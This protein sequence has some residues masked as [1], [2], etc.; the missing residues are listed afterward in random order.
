MTFITED[1]L[2]SN[3]VAVELYHGT[4]KEL[5]IVDY[6]C[7]L[8]PKD[9]AINRQFANLYEIWLE[10]D[11]YKWRAMRTAG[12]PEEK[13]TGGATPLE[14]FMAYAE[15]VPLTLRNPL[16]HWSHLELQRYFG[17][18][19][20]LS[21]NTAA[22]IWEQANSM[23]QGDDFTT[24]GL[25]KKFRV[26]VVCTT[27]DPVDDLRWHRE[28]FGKETYTRTFPAF[29]PDKALAVDQP[30]V[31]VEWLGKLEAAADIYIVQ[32]ADFLK[33]L[34]QRLSFFHDCGCRL[35]DH[36]L[37]HAFA[38]ACSTEEAAE[39]FAQARRGVEANAEQKRKFAAYLLE[40]F[41]E[42]YHERGWVS[43]FHLGAQ[44][45]NSQR[46]LRELG[47]DT[48]F[49][50]IGDWPQASALAR[51][52]DALDRKGKLGKTIL[53]NLNPADNYVFGTMIGNFQEGPCR[54]KIQFGSGWWFNDQ[55]EGMEAQI[56]ALSNLGLLSLFVG[57]LTDSR[58]FMSF[59]RH[60]YFRRILCNLI[61]REVD[62]GELPDD[63][64]LLS[65]LVE[66]VCH[67]NAQEYF[68]FAARDFKISNDVSI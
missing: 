3:D 55:K 37:N 54:G 22:E 28:L 2:L 44:R 67:R 13:I 18:E 20:L 35:A 43:Q 14:K 19:T 58:S 64:A 42:C 24:Q 27:D 48:G 34:E 33:A 17:I 6:H 63:W 12:V 38:G 25:L 66:G 23:L 21:P 46:R 31:F 65:S 7:H 57:M 51:L 47:P 5:P 4:A 59:P 50:S 53:Y 40:W 32:F 41:G 1:F 30:A 45:S 68:P 49:D 16:Y 15:T 52:L 29:R 56:N 39:I 9:V 26:E 8:P 36:G 62:A 11:H 10:G 60:E 61:G